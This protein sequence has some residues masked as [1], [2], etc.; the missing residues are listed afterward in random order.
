MLLVLA[1]G[2]EIGTWRDRQPPPIIMLRPIKPV[3]EAPKV[4]VDTTLKVPAL[5]PK[6]LRRIEKQIERPLATVTPAGEVID[7]KGEAIPGGLGSSEVLLTATELPPAPDGG[8]VVVT[9]K[10]DG[11]VGVTLVRK[12]EKLIE[13]RPQYAV[14]VLVDPAG[15]GDFRGYARASL[16][17][18]A[19]VHLVAE[20]GMERYGGR[21]TAAGYALVGI[22]WRF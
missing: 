22:E 16:L 3:A 10:P 18:V 13:F 12:P 5:P 20:A 1:L 17:R 8:E 21:S 7:S 9:R 19:R 15:G 11:E 6:K 2:G 4:D 14:G